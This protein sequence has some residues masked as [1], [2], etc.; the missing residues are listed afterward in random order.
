VRSKQE[1]HPLALLSLQF[2]IGCTVVPDGLSVQ[3]LNGKEGVVKQ[4]SRER[5]GVHFPERAVTALKPQRLKLLHEAPEFE[6][7]PAKRQDKQQK[8]AR[9]K[10]LERQE[11]LQ[12]CR[13]FV[14]C[15]HQDQ[16]PEMGT[17][18]VALVLAVWQGLVK[19]KDFTAENIA[20]EMVKG[21]LQT[22]FE[23]LT[24]ELAASRTPNSTYASDLAAANF[25]ATEWDAL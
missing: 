17:S 8:E 14:E 6:Q 1:E 24:R 23:E 7:P 5:V 4:Y 18:A 15:L 16:Y 11:A 10:D 22:R 21:S 9:W 3:E 20:E 19:H 2:P 13:R 12:I 25:A